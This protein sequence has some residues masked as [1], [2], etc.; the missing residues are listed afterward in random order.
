MSEEQHLSQVFTTTKIDEI[1]DAVTTRLGRQFTHPQ[2]LRTLFRLT[3][4]KP[5]SIGGWLPENWELGDA[6]DHEGNLIQRVT[7]QGEEYR[8]A[9]E[10]T[11]R[12]VDAPNI[13]EPFPTDVRSF[14]EIT[15]MLVHTTWFNYLKQDDTEAFG[16]IIRN[17]WTDPAVAF[18]EQIETNDLLATALCLVHYHRVS[19]K[20]LELPQTL[21]ELIE[22]WYEHWVVMQEATLRQDE[23][24]PNAPRL[25]ADTVNRNNEGRRVLALERAKILYGRMYPNGTEG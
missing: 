10:N 9:Q 12:P 2:P 4:I 21:E 11:P 19:N 22:F 6:S 25:D 14:L 17:Q 24:Q 5:V 15:W 13:T 18:P 7:P 16:V 8:E 23:R 1:F 3:A 20:F